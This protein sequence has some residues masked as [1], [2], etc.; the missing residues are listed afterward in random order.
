LLLLKR[1]LAGNAEAHTRNG[2]AASLRNRL[3]TL[4]TI[5]R[6]LTATKLA[7]CPLHFVFNARVYL[8]LNCAIP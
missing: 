5:A 7:P 3:V 6:T 8:I 4:L 1:R 2:L